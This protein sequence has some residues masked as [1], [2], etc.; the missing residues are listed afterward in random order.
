MS[1]TPRKINEIGRE[2]FTTPLSRQDDPHVRA[3]VPRAARDSRRAPPRPRNPARSSRLRHLRHRQR[4][5]RQLEPVLASIGRRAAPRSA[6]RR[7]SAGGARSCR[8]DSI[9]VRCA[10]PRGRPRSWTRFV[11]SRQF[12][13]SGTR[14]IPKMP[15]RREHRATDVERRRQIARRRAAT[16]GCR[17]ARAPSRTAPGANGSA[18]MS[19]RTRRSEFACDCAGRR[20]ARRRVAARVRASAPTDRCRRASTPARASGSETRPVPQPSSRTGPSRSQRDAAPERHVAAAERPRVLP[21][22]E[23]RVLVPALP[24]FASHVRSCDAPRRWMGDTFSSRTSTPP[25]TA[26]ARAAG[27]REDR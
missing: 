19:P 16:A 13:T 23:R 15:P 8:T 21:V 5:E 7:S 4:P 18:R 25:E 22:V 17:T 12:G 9:S 10:P 26:G 20:A 27:R 1:E 3:L 6:A 2:N 24:A 11:Y 14:S